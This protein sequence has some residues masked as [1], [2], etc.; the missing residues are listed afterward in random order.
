LWGILF[1]YGEENALIHY[2]KHCDPSKT[3][4]DHLSMIYSSFS[5]PEPVG[6][7]KLSKDHFEIPSFI[8][9]SQEDPI[10]RKY[11]KEKERIQKIY[12][13]GD[14]LEITLGRLGIGEPSF[15][16]KRGHSS[17]D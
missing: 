3:V 15:V 16:N 12:S 8:S 11:E 6:Q 17:A 10:Q 14:F 4:R 2:W 1:G 7:V 13:N 9:Y 5:T